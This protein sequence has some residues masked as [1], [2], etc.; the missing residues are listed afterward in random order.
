MKDL[1]FDL[2][3][4]YWDKPNHG[5]KG[6]GLNNKVLYGVSLSV[7]VQVVYLAERMYLEIRAQKCSIV[8][9]RVDLGYVCDHL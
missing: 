2:I 3:L 8:G 7:C 5:R 1:A 6:F 9:R 4:Y